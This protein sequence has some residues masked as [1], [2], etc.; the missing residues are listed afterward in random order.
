[1]A[2]SN[3]RGPDPQSGVLFSCQCAWFICRFRQKGQSFAQQ[4]WQESN[5]RPPGW[6]RLSVPLDYTPSSVPIQLSVWPRNTK[7]PPPLGSGSSTNWTYVSPRYAVEGTSWGSV[8]TQLKDWVFNVWAMAR[9]RDVKR[10]SEPSGCRCVRHMPGET[11]FMVRMIYRQACL[12]EHLLNSVQFSRLPFRYLRE[13]ALSYTS[14][15]QTRDSE[16]LRTS[17][18]AFAMGDHVRAL[19]EPIERRDD[20]C[21]PSL[22]TSGALAR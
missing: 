1:V 12:W 10:L 11:R 19:R 4:G 13:V 15:R 8:A 22:S 17:W 9:P 14:E 6:S 2:T 16:P 5:P 3:R 20:R 18:R 7:E 21:A